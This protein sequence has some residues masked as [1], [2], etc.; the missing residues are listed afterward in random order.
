[1]TDTRFR[2]RDVDVAPDEEPRIAFGEYSVSVVGALNVGSASCNR[3][4]LAGVSYAP[5]AGQLDVLVAAGDRF[6]PLRS[7]VCSLD[8]AID[9]YEVV[10]GFAGGLPERVV[11]TE[12]DAVYGAQSAHLRR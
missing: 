3:A 9:G 8:T 5:A 12:H 1:M 4:R 11:A 10:V 2:V 6:R 7:A